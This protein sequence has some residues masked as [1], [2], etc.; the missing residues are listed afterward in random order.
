MAI[1]SQQSLQ[2]ESEKSFHFELIS[3]VESKLTLG[4]KP[5]KLKEWVGLCRQCDAPTTEKVKDFKESDKRRIRLSFR[6]EE[7]FF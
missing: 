6:K 4:R 1:P 3:E 5:H 2:P 7:S